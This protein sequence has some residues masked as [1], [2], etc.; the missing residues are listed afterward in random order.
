M[1]K[2]ILY[3]AM[4]LDGYIADK[5]GGVDFLVG[6]GSEPDNIGSYSSFIETVDTIIMGYTTYHQI[7]TELSPN[8]WVYKR[9]KTYVLTSKDEKSTDE[10]IFTNFDIMSLLN[11]LKSDDGKSIWICGGA[12]IVNQALD[13]I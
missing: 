5:I 3:I 9:K 11:K 13:F 6:D 2:V 4:S 1:R 8:E 12:S 7:V 10:I